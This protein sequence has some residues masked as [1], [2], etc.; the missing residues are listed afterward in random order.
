[1]HQ[2]M[3]IF[4]IADIFTVGRREIL[5]NKIHDYRERNVKNQ[6]RLWK[7]RWHYQVFRR[8]IGLFSIFFST[9]THI[10]ALT[11]VIRNDKT[12]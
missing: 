11:E 10:I 9:H 6:I 5:F 12:D 4:I 8:L 3:Q 1:M 2:V 7:W